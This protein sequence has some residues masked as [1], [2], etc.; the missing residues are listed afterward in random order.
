MYDSEQKE[1]SIIIFFTL[2]VSL[3]LWHN[4]G[5]LSREI[6][7]YKNLVKK[8]YHISFV[9]YGDQSEFNY[10]IGNID[11]IPI[12]SSMP[13]DGNVWMKIIYILKFIFSKN[14]AL[15]QSSLYMTHQMRGA[16]LPIIFKYK[17]KVPVIIRC[18][19]EWFRN[20]IRDTKFIL[21]KIV[22]IMSGYIYEW[23]CYG[24]ADYIII[25]N[26]SDKN[27]INKFFL[28]DK[29]KIKMIRNYIDPVIFSPRKDGDKLK[30][31]KDTVLFVG[32]I[33]K[34][35]NIDSVIR[36]LVNTNYDFHIIGVGPEKKY[37]KQL[38]KQNKVNVK[39]LGKI[40]NAKL[41]EIIKRYPV[42][43]QPSFYENSPK[44]LMEAMAC[45][46]GIIATNVEGN[47]E[48]ICNKEN[49]LLCS[50]EIESIR[51]SIITLIEDKELR[52]SLGKNSANFISDNCSIH[53]ITN[54]YIGVI[55]KIIL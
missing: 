46:I 42:F 1:K 44:T 25:S 4:S 32:R 3:K 47:Y 13:R 51:H 11:V 29:S 21:K 31:L 27:F 34:R 49:G 16:I 36:A 48:L 26:I 9:T 43:I 24:F 23:V 6:L 2:G 5:I 54:N 35:K 12:F 41:G 39:F 10:E 40:S 7:L 17:Y 55:N 22:N 53:K 19:H 20:R 37:L 50:L 45:G 38:A 52:T 15:A 30:V 28:I 18:G 14:K 8:G 33:I